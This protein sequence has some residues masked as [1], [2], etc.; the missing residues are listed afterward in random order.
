MLNPDFSEEKEK[1]AF[2][3]HIRKGDLQLGKKEDTT[4]ER[5]R[6]LFRE[7]KMGTNSL[8]REKRP[9]RKEEG[10]LK[11]EKKGKI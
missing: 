9:S 10:L 5:G 8:T 3:K 11:T 2:E 1:S 7:K 4:K 6:G